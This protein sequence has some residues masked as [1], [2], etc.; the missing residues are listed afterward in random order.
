MEK[1]LFEYKN[2]LRNSL[3]IAYWISIALCVIFVMINYNPIRNFISLLIFSVIVM[4]LI[5][6]IKRLK[7]YLYIDAIVFKE[8]GWHPLIENE[9]GVVFENIYDYKIKNIG[10]TLI[11][12]ELKRRNGKTLRRLLSLTENELLELSETLNKKVR[13]LSIT[14]K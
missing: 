13:S 7:I 5:W 8:K 4:L 1:P 3:T 2:R 14:V 10:F 9:F 12:I 6:P 11:W